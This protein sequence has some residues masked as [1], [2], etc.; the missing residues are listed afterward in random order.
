MGVFELQLGLGAP[1]IAFPNHLMYR[2][3]ARIL[4]AVLPPISGGPFGFQIGFSGPT[5]QARSQRINPLTPVPNYTFDRRGQ[6]S[7]YVGG[8]G[9]EGCAPDDEVRAILGYSRAA[10][11]WDYADDVR[12][13]RVDSTWH[14]FTNALTWA[15]KGDWTPEDWDSLAGTYPQPWK[16]VDCPAHWADQDYP[17]CTPRIIADY[18]GDD[19]D[20]CDAVGIWGLVSYQTLHAFILIN[21]GGYDDEVLAAAEMRAPLMWRAEGV[22][23][24]RYRI[25]LGGTGIA[26]RWSQA[27]ARKILSGTALPW[28]DYQIVPLQ[29]TTVGDDAAY[30]DLTPAFDPT[31][32]DEWS[33]QD[34]VPPDPGPPEV[35]EVLPY[36]YLDME[37]MPSWVNNSEEAVTVNSFAVIA[38]NAGESATEILFWKP[39]ELPIEIPVG[40]SLL[41]DGF[42][43]KLSEVLDG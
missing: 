34:Y 42:T 15:R 4:R 10:V 23:S 32:A 1:V 35:V 2:S 43:L 3:H 26:P 11:T 25:R 28:S 38:W 40:D 13:V 17:Y 8:Y 29:D 16:W 9:N 39:A 24:V 7:D 27:V 21:S 37:T 41:L 14:Q 22:L 31:D 12:G 19:C 33:V 36:A 18:W 6:Y 20:I 5:L 30:D